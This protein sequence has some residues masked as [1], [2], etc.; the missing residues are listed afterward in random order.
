MHFAL[1][2]WDFDFVFA[3]LLLHC[4]IEFASKP[5]RLERHLLR[6]YPQ[7]KVQG[8]LAKPSEKYGRLGFLENL[9]MFPGHFQQKPPQ[10]IEI[11]AVSHADGK[12]KPNPRVAVAPVG[13]SMADE[14]GI[15]HDDGDIIIRYDGRAPQA[16]LPD[17]SSHAPNFDSVSDGDGPFGQNDQSA[18]KIIDDILEAKAN[19]HP[20]RPGH[21]RERSQIDANHLQGN[22]KPKHDEDVT[23]NFGDGELQRGI[24]AGPLE[25]TRAEM[26]AQRIL[27]QQNCDQEHHQLDDIESRELTLAQPKQG[28]IH[29]SLEICQK[30]THGGHFEEPCCSWRVKSW[31]ASNQFS[32]IG[33]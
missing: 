24:Q 23:T 27:R 5:A 4:K 17:L 14:I 28:V 29:D 18:D 30:P 33:N 21:D 1:W 15:R 11:C 2:K 7:F 8:T 3:Q 16:N 9:G 6:P 26:P 22:I 10:F 32:V 19:A 13:H 31:K 25:H 20:N 12:A